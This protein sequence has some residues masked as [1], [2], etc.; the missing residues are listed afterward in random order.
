MDVK[1]RYEVIAEFED[2]KRQLIISRDSLDE[3][4]RMQKMKVKQVRRQLEDM[5]ED[6]NAF[7]KN[8]PGQ[9]TTLDTLIDSTN[10]TLNRFHD[11]KANS[12]S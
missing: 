10:D 1:S 3:E 11:I 7:E 4:L 5:E 12:R 6:V 8:I 2:K 9:K